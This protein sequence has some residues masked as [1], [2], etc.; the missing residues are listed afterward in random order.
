MRHRPPRDGL[1]GSL[2]GGQP[3]VMTP[4]AAKP[5]V[6]IYLVCPRCSLAKAHERDQNGSPICPDCW[7]ESVQVEMQVLVSTMGRPPE[8]T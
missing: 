6:E 8:S 5:N 1:F 4:P 7:R 3:L 2:P